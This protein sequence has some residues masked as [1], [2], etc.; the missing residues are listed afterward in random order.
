MN[1]MPDCPFCGSSKVSIETK[2]KL[3]RHIKGSR[4]NTVTASARCNKCFAR[5]PIV[6]G[7]VIDFQSSSIP[8]EYLSLCT[9]KEYLKDQ[10]AFAWSNRI[11]SIDTPCSAWNECWK[12]IKK[13]K[14]G[15]EE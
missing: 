3:Y 4:I 1:S 8:D 13:M 14:G 12:T 2:Q 10:A 7:K 9:T 15:T 11:N 6:S 5:G